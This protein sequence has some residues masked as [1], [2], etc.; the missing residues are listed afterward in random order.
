MINF[1]SNMAVFV[2][3]FVAS[4]SCLAGG[5]ETSP[6]DEKSTSMVSNKNISLI[7]KNKFYIE[8]LI[9]SGIDELKSSGEYAGASGD[10]YNWDSAVGKIGNVSN[11]EDLTKGIK[12]GYFVNENVRVD[13]S[14]YSLG[15]GSLKWD[16]DFSSQNGTFNS[17]YGQPFR[18]GELK[19]QAIFL[20][21]YY[22]WSLNSKFEPYVGIGLGVSRNEFRSTIESSQQTVKSNKQ[23]VFAYKLDIGSTYKIQPSVLLNLGVSFIDIGDF[24][25]G[26][27]RT[28][29]SDGVVESI[30]PYKF[31]SDGLS[32]VFAFSVIYT[33]NR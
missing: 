29:H 24:R 2:F 27:V 26:S 11:D 15:F 31:R 1:L 32:P 33:F 4:M 3:V 6:A 7:K 10:N 12:V 21:T 5:H 22:N 23:N 20:S 25:S 18:K 17:A 13:L 8:G 9:G 19:S 30:S 28:R 16:T 14:Y